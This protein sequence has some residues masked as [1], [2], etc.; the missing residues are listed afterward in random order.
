MEGKQSESITRMKGTDEQFV[1]ET[2]MEYKGKLTAD[3][4]AGTRPPTDLKH[5]EN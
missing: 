3:V 1:S 5:F 2:Y 4:R